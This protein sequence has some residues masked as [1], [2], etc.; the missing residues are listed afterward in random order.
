MKARILLS[1]RVFE[2]D[3]CDLVLCRD[4]NASRNIEIRGAAVAAALF[5]ERGGTAPVALSMRRGGPA[6]MADGAEVGNPFPADV[7]PPPGSQSDSL[8]AFGHSGM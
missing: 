5:E 1:E 8:D 7:N 3:E 2:C 6:A 4:V